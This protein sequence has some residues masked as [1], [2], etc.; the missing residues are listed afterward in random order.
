MAFTVY[1]VL[2][3]SKFLL[4]LLVSVAEPHGLKRMTMLKAQYSFVM[5]SF[6]RQSCFILNEEA[7]QAGETTSNINFPQLYNFLIYHFNSCMLSNFTYFF[8]VFGSFLKF[9]T[10]RHSSIYSLN[11]LHA[12]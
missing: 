4:F 12:G 7:V 9:V 6:R 11:S 8:V 10:L 1:S 3:K 5:F 2:A